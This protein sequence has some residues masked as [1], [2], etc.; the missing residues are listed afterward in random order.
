MVIL[1]LCFS[2]ILPLMTLNSYDRVIFQSQFNSIAKFPI[3]ANSYTALM[4]YFYST[5]KT[6]AKW[7]SDSDYE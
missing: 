6:F 4:F 3:K 1:G 7:N 5:I 2:L